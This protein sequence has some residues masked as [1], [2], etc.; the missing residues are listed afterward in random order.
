MATKNDTY[1]VFTPSQP[2]E[3]TFVE[4]DEVNKQLVD[5]IRTPGKQLVIYG[6]SGSGK[7]TLLNNKLNQL[8]SGVIESQC[9]K[10]TTIDQLKLEAFDLLDKYYKTEMS[11][12][13]S[14]EISSSLKSLYS[15][16]KAS[17]KIQIGDRLERIVP[18]QL[19]DS[20]LA[21]LIGE[22]ESCWKIEDFH[23][24]EKE[25]KQRLSQIMK[26]FMDASRK[27]KTTKIITIGAVGTGKEVVE[28]DSEMKERVSE[29]YIPLM[30]VDELEDIITKGEKL[31]NVEFPKDIKNKIVVYSNGLGSICHQL[32]LSM[33]TNNYIY[34]TADEKYT[35]S[36]TDLELAINDYL[37]QN[38]ATLKS[39]FDKAIKS[40]RKSKYGTTEILQAIIN[41]KKEEVNSH[42]IL[43]ELRD[44]YDSKYPSS[45][46]TT[47][48]NQLI[49]SER[50]EVLRI[51]KDSNTYYFS[52]PFQKAY[53]ELSFRNKSR[54]KSIGFN[55]LSADEILAF[56][57]AK[58]EIEAELEDYDFD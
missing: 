17:S 22:A 26:V 46:L 39:T 31:L 48:L 50:D 58:K 33:C 38:S 24:V 51:N 7:T 18:I 23:K 56:I 43:D 1:S 9:N 16:I 44:K 8:Y 12:Q 4:R 29:I 41:L 10:S 15:E 36:K 52:N 34:E 54:T 13:K 11:T 30:S 19:T 55:K 37:S 49:T 21:E 42:E 45:T 35:F 6:Y 27:Y 47:Y 14:F 40:S 28:Y 25:H 3:L 20:R 53:F 32:C 57:Q 5:A 2:A